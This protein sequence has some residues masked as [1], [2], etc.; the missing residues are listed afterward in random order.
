M[1]C[2][3]CGGRKTEK[4]TR[5]GDRVI[6]MRRIHNIK[7]KFCRKLERKN[8]LERERRKEKREKRQKIE[9]PR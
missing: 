8:E 4:R 1:E 2:G 5:G 6:E 7:F 3:W 9:I